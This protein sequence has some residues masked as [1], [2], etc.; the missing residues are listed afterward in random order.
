MEYQ[1]WHSR[2]GAEPGVQ[3]CAGLCR[4]LQHCA[5]LRSTAQQCKLNLLRPTYTLYLE[6]CRLD[7]GK[8]LEWAK[9]KV[10][11]ETGGGQILC[12]VLLPVP[13]STLRDAHNKKVYGAAAVAV[14]HTRR[15]VWA[16][17]AARSTTVG[18]G[19]KPILD[20][21]ITARSSAEPGATG[22]ALAVI[23]S[24]APQ[25]LRAGSAAAPTT[26]YVALLSVLHAIF[27]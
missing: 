8:L 1:R 16:C 24:C 17:R 9:D 6:T 15:V 5:A 2:A 18:A 26:V 13:H 19:L 27:T 4:G 12:S 21:I 7:S 25:A 11:A 14:V 10:Q 20:P 23:R 3:H 22:A